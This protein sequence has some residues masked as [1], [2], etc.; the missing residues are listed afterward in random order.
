MEEEEK[1]KAE[2]EN[3]TCA[4]AKTEHLCLCCH[5]RQMQPKRLAEL[6]EI[7]FLSGWQMNN[8]AK[9]AAVS[10]ELS[11]KKHQTMKTEQ[12]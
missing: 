3:K 7:H 2:E 12:N 10:S 5:L 6:L 11:M 4:R 1:S 9:N 8:P